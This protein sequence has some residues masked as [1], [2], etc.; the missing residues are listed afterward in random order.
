[1]RRIMAWCQSHFFLVLSFTE[2]FFNSLAAVILIRSYSAACVTAGL[3][4]A[5][6]A[7]P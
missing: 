5:K 6:H 4:A 7:K 3:G 1:T 2:D